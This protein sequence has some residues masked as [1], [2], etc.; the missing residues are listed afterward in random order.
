MGNY[1]DLRLEKDMYKVASKSF[2]Q[3]L[4]SLDPTE[5]YKGTALYDLD[6][7]QRQLKRFDI[8]VSGKTSDTVEKFFQTSDSAALFPEYV[9]R[10]VLQGINEANNLSDIV[11]TTTK[12][13]SLDYRTISTNNQGTDKEL[14]KVAEGAIIPK[15]TIKTKENLISLTKKGRMLVASYEALRFQKLDLFTVALK[16]IGAY[17]AKS[18]MKQALDTIISGDG[19]N[20]AAQSFSVGTSPIG[21]TAQSITYSELVDFWGQFN[22]YELN[23]LV[24]SNDVMLKLLNISELK[25][26][27]NGFEFIKNGKMITPMGAKV[28]RSSALPSS[29]IIG[30]DKNYA[31]EMVEASDVIVEYDKLIDRQLERASITTIA[32]FAKIFD[33]AS[34][35]LNV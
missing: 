35:V 21:G 13:D 9:S 32:G 25:N 2:T 3:V 5:N 11:A 31:L 27:Q 33:D 19:N 6:A 29:T 7:Y 26:V 12:I 1:K 15:T 4:E 17:I 22:D 8:K 30:L 24:V 18:R 34:K 20:N 14:K 28:I 10:A 16:Q 23:T